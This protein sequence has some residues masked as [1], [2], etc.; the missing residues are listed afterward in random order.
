MIIMVQVEEQLLVSFILRVL[1]KDRDI[2]DGESLLLHPSVLANVDVVD[3]VQVLAMG[4][5]E[6]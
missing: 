5:Y 2:V 4:N 1:C 3:V 6:W